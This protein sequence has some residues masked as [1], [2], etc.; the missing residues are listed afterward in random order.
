[1]TC[2][3]REI[4]QLLHASFENVDN[5]LDV[6]FEPEEVDAVLRKLK[7]GK[8]A[9]YDGVQADHS[10]YGGPILRDWILQ[11]CNAIAVFEEVPQNG[12]HHPGV[13]RRCQKIHLTQII[14]VE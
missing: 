6:T 9:G 11:V 2:T 1:M 8:A 10:K 3:D 13:Q 14:I 4:E 12:N 5:I 7:W